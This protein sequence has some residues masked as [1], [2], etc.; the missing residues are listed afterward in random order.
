M[1][2]DQH[3]ENMEYVRNIRPETENQADDSTV[4]IYIVSWEIIK[5]KDDGD[6]LKQVLLLSTHL[7][8]KFG[9]VW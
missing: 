8:G 2:Y 3:A 6:L 7:S 4:K 5:K 9:K 1:N